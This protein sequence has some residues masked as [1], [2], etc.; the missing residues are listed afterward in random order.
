[1]WFL[2]ML[3]EHRLSHLKAIFERE[4]LSSSILPSVTDVQLKDVGV[5]RFGDRQKVLNLAVR[6]A[7]MSTMD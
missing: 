2:G 7:Q 1:M 4:R 6:F 3:E 5:K